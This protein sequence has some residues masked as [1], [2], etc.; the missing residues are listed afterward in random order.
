MTKFYVTK[1][2]QKDLYTEKRETQLK[3]SQEKDNILF[4]H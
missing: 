1:T 2:K 3:W 4:P